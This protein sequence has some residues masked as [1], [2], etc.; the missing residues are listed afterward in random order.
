MSDN[1]LT[2]RKIYNLDGSI[3]HLYRINTRDWVDIKELDLSEYY[4]RSDGDYVRQ[5]PMVMLLNKDDV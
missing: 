1:I 4:E 2:I 3:T 5:R